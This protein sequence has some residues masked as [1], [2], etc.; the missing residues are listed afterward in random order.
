MAKYVPKL[1]TKLTTVC[2]NGSIVEAY[3]AHDVIAANPWMPLALTQL[4]MA[5]ET[6]GATSAHPEPLTPTKRRKTGWFELASRPSNV[7]MSFDVTMADHW[8]LVHDRV[9]LAALLCLIGVSF[10]GAQLPD[11]R[12]L[13]N[14]YLRKLK[15]RIP[16]EQEYDRIVLL[17]DMPRGVVIGGRS[18]P[19]PIKEVFLLYDPI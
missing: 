17:G 2:A 3:I 6:L 14:P 13:L 15:L 5:A 4:R 16:L 19:G 8:A 12:I 7:R 10:G 9:P 1:Y 11:P 18:D